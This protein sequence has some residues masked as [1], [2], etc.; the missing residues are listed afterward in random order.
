MEIAKKRNKADIQNAL[1]RSASVVKLVRGVANNATW[2][3]MMD[4]HDAIK[5]HPNYRGKVKYLY[6][7]AFKEF[8]N[9]ER[10]LLY[11]NENRMFHLADMTPTTRKIYGNITDAQYFEYWQGLGA[12]AYTEGNQWVSS[13]DNKYRL[14]L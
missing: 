9:N 7:Q 8:K 5:K 4:A 6:K 13:L 3:V 2:L 14:S 10:Q 11:A 12:R 1:A